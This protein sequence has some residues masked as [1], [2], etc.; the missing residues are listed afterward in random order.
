MPNLGIVWESP[1]CQHLA[2]WGFS[3]GTVVCSGNQELSVLA[4]IMTS[5]NLVHSTCY[6]DFVIKARQ[7]QEAN[8]KQHRITVAFLA[9]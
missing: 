5:H 1:H 6:R 4:A 3:N 7:L 9:I 8:R 2:L